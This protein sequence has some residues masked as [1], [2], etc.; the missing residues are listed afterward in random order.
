MISVIIT[1]LN[2]V[3]TIRN[4]ITHVFASAI[5][6]RLLKEVIVVDGGSTDGTLQEA[7]KTGATVISAPA[8]RKAEQL[9]LGA[10][11]AS[12]DILYFLPSRSMPPDNFLAEIVKAVTRGKA[13]GTFTLRFDRRYWLLN[14]LSWVTT[15]FE[16]FVLM[17]QSLFITRALFTKAGGFREDRLVMIHQELIRRITRYTDFVVLPGTIRASSRKYFQRG[18]LRT[19]LAQAT[20]YLLYQWGYSQDSLAGI[21]R[22]LLRWKVGKEP[23]SVQHEQTI[24]EITLRLDEAALSNG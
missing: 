13:S 10:L 14:S 3:S 21:Y 19:E 17:D 9:N 1:T 18:V 15:H 24:G 11:Q 5:Y 16:R 23:Q 12:G 20:V 8:K 22:R 6:K 2:D 4:T 7:E